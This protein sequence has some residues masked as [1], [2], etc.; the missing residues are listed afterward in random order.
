[1]P[2]I[3]RWEEGGKTMGE[4]ER[5]DVDA[6]KPSEMVARALLMKAKDLQGG[7]GDRAREQLLNRWD[8]MTVKTVEHLGEIDHRVRTVIMW[9]PR[10]NVDDSR[11]IEGEAT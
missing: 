7:Y 3:R 10:P 4:I 9:A 11:L 6:L 5:M 1:M 8:G 2:V